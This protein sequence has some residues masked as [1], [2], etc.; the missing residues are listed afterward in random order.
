MNNALRINDATHLRSRAIHGLALAAG[1]AAAAWKARAL[2]A[3]GALVATLV[4]AAV[5]SGMGTRG[6]IATVGY[7]AA[8]S[9]L[10][11]LPRQGQPVQRRGNRRDAVQ[12][13]A[14]GGPA[15]LFSLMR[16]FSCGTSSDLPVAAFYGSLA[17]ASAD[18]WATEIGTRWGGAPRSI[19][20]GRRTSSGESG[21][22][23]MA[24]L[25]GSVLASLTIAAVA[26][27]GKANQQVL[28]ISCAAGGIAGSLTDSL[29][30]AV[31]QEQRWC[32]RCRA[33]TEM[34]VHSCGEPTRHLS[35]VPSMNNDVVNVLAV[36]AG[37]LT[38]ATLSI[39]LSK[40]TERNGSRVEF[41]TTSTSSRQPTDIGA[42]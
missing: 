1:I 25:A 36:V 21:A 17:A 35:G 42:P 39:A 4:G 23:T 27:S 8:S 24:G 11:R 28:A 14:N 5:H 12:V 16:V 38:A 40:L 15:A 33:R 37:G 30:G 2:S 18:T 19:A 32:A 6:S 20:T 26:Q 34:H 13:L 31:V 41:V 7:F 9:A 22:V 29:L 10:G 3:S